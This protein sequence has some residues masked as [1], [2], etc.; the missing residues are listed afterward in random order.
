MADTVI[1]GSLLYSH[2]IPPILAFIGV[3]LLCSGIMDG[4]RNYAIA[5]VVLFFA[6]GLLPFL[7][8]PVILGT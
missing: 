7:I 3:I 1:F 4:K 5:G 2:I 6:A 8:L